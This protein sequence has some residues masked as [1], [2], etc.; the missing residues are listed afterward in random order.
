MS[1]GEWT[2]VIQ[3]NTCKTIESEIN[4]E[5]SEYVKETTTTLCWKRTL[6][7]FLS[8]NQ[9]LRHKNINQHSQNIHKY[10]HHISIS[11]IYIH[12]Q[13]CLFIKCLELKYC[14]TF[15][16]N[17]LINVLILVVLHTNF[18]ASSTIKLELRLM[19]RLGKDHLMMCFK[20]LW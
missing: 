3:N 20:Q 14:K 5:W 10:C 9:L 11:L 1:F 7:K 2:L 19:N 6:C 4:W 17:G 16:G 15:I 13:G 18:F 12:G 8:F